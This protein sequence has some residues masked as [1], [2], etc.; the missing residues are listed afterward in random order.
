MQSSV[1]R[2]I[3]VLLA[4]LLC[5]SGAAASLCGT[6]SSFLCERQAL[7]FRRGAD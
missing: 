1:G 2:T 6:A 4:A 7:G 3:I 5:A